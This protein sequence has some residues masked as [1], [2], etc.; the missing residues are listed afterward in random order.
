MSDR[1]E[2]Y[3]DNGALVV[4]YIDSEE[5]LSDVRITS[6]NSANFL[7]W[8]PAPWVIDGELII[9]DFLFN[10]ETNGHARISLDHVFYLTAERHRFEALRFRNIAPQSLSHPSGRSRSPSLTFQEIEDV[11]AT[12]VPSFER[13]VVSS[14]LETDVGNI[15]AVF[16]L[17]VRSRQH[18][19]YA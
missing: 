6:R 2:T 1:F 17:Q 16:D 7:L 12:V 13:R 19:Q 8:M 15:D 14:R 10:P 18:G 9:Q 5:K 4:T 3:L 11:V